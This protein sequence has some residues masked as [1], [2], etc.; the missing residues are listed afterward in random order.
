MLDVGSRSS[1]GI[2]LGSRDGLG[3]KGGLEDESG[4]WACSS[5]TDVVEKSTREL[6][7]SSDWNVPLFQDF[8]VGLDQEERSTSGISLD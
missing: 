4:V 7:I 2:S 6:D 8:T 3:A 5:E 1:W